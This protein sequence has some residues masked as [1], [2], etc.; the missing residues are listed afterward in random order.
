M[1]GDE[2]LHRAYLCILQTEAEARSHS[3]GYVLGLWRDI[4]VTTHVATCE[5][6]AATI[7]V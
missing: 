1:S 4:S 5:T 3:R 7:A 6:C 2:Y